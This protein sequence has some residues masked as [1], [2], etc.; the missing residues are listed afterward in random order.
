MLC[1]DVLTSTEFRKRYASLTEPTHVTVSG[2][3]IGTWQPGASY[4]HW[5]NAPNCRFCR[6]EAVVDH[7]ADCP[8][9]EYL[10]R[11]PERGESKA[12]FTVLAPSTR[13]SFTPAP[14]PA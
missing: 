11:R 8:D 7:E 12:L 3:V 1:M 14:K 9:P 2:H 5:D 4:R 6:A 13:P 10:A